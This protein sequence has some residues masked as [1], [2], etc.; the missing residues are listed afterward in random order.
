VLI[1]SVLALLVL[2]AGI[3]GWL[4]STGYDPLTASSGPTYVRLNG[5]YV[6][7]V[8]AIEPSSGHPMIAYQVSYRNGA[9]LE[10]GFA[11]I[12]HSPFPITVEEVG[13]SHG[14]DFPPLRQEDVTISAPGDP[15]WG[16]QLPGHQV[17]FQTFS[18]PPNDARFVV[19]S[20]QLFGCA[21]AKQNAGDVY[22]MTARVTYR[23]KVAGVTIHRSDFLPLSY[24]IRVTGCD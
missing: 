11:L 18:L 4:V 22:E 12:N 2:A 8:P 6:P 23:M 10:H 15:A 3:A 24:S 5:D 7:H 16:P 14:P 19:V 1:A 20:Q 17:P 9:L 13:W 21:R